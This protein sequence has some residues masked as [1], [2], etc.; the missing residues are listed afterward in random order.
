MEVLHKCLLNKVFSSVISKI[1]TYWRN[2]VNFLCILY[3]IYIFVY[4]F[5]NICIAI[6]KSPRLV[7]LKIFSAAL[8]ICDSVFSANLPD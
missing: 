1:F 8:T 7:H 2:L 3:C 4:V 5:F 6:K